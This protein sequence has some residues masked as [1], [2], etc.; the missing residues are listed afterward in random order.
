MF[1]VD[2]GSRGEVTIPRPGEDG[3][4]GPPPS[5]ALTARECEILEL[6]AAGLSNRQ[7][8]ARLVISPKTVKNHIWNLYQRMGVRGRGQAVS[9]WRELHPNDI[10][11]H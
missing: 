4:A 9:R 8:A 11:S 2:A 10:T 3:L 1:L 5:Y 7:I 6:I